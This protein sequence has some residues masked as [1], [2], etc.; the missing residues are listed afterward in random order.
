MIRLNFLLIFCTAA[1]ILY[2]GCKKDEAVQLSHS[3][4]EFYIPQNFPEPYDYY[5]QN[6]ITEAGFALGKKLF[7]D[8]ILSADSTISC[9]SCHQQFSAFAHLGHDVSHGINGLLGTRNAPSLFNL[10][11]KDDFLWDGG[12]EHIEFVP[13]NAITASFEM[14]ETMAGVVDKLRNHQNYPGLFEA[15]FENDSVNSQ[16][17]LRALSQF[18][19]L[20]IS[21]DSKYDQWLANKAAVFLTN[22]ELEGLQLFNTNCGECHN[23]ILFTDLS[24]RNNGL[25]ENFSDAGRARITGLATDSGKFKVPSL[26]NVAVSS[27]YMHDGRFS[28]LEQ[29]L[30]HYANGVVSSSTLDPLLTDG[31]DLT[32]EEQEKIIAFLH[33]LTDSGFL[34][35]EKFSNPF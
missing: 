22:K 26:R 28:S 19:G 30:A 5:S 9:G 27:P 13:V 6:P 2:S 11:W 18:M 31:I 35:D 8:P 1:A 3:G 4:F 21:A 23:G 12:V 32:E 10:A 15:A 33:T 17:L 7:Y 29:V 24:F 34:T 25:D 16:N 20:M 14:D